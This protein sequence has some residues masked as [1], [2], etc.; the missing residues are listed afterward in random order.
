VP[1]AVARAEA[2]GAKVVQP[3]TQMPWGQTVAYVTDL[4]GFLVEIC[5][6]MGG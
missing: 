4:D 5:T 6:P 1:A 3:A 2:A